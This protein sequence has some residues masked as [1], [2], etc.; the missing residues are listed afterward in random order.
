MLKKSE[1]WQA[2]LFTMDRGP[3]PVWSIHLYCEC[4]QICFSHRITSSCYLIFIIGCKVNYH[5]NFRVH[6]G[7][8]IY[9]DKIPDLVQI[10]EHQFAEQKLINLWIMMMLLSWTSAT[11]CARVYNMGFTSNDLARLAIQITGNL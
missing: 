6:E 3:I 7:Q 4:T 8:R 5:H 2:V 10:G 11:N 9:Y 1:A